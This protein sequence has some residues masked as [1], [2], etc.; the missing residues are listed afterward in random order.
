MVGG[1]TE[2]DKGVA[3]EG[4]QL[5]HVRILEPCPG[6]DRST[7]TGKALTTAWAE[8]AVVA[9]RTCGGGGGSGAAG[10]ALPCV[11]VPL[12]RVVL[13]VREGCDDAWL[14]MQPRALAHPPGGVR[15]SGVKRER[16]QEGAEE[17]RADGPG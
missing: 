4:V 2:L 12:P 6:H 1:L 15:G 3:E 17:S 14:H 5:V 13:R 10:V 16:G 9:G 11:D 7:N 8:G